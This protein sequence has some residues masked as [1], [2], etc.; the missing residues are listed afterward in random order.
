VPRPTPVAVRAAQ[1]WARML[2]RFGTKKCAC[3]ALWAAAERAMANGQRPLAQELFALYDTYC[4][5]L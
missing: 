2:R 5:S 1:M 4:L 3:A